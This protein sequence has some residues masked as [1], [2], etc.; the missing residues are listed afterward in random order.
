MTFLHSFVCTCQMPITPPAGGSA[1]LLGLEAQPSAPAAASAS[2]AAFLVDVFGDSA[3]PT[4]NGLDPLGLTPGAEEN[5][6]KSV[7]ITLRES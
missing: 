3:Q 5:V 2:S 6:K 1:D 7:F 4:S